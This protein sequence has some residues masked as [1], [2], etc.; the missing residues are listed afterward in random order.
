MAII[1][2][3]KTEDGLITELPVLNKIVMGRSGISD[4]KI[5]DIKMSGKHCSFEVNG[6]GQLLFTDLG[7]TNGSFL[8]N[9]QVNKTMV[10]VND[11]IRIGNTLIKIDEKRLST[12]E[13]LAIGSSI[14][15]K[16]DEKTL[17]DIS[18]LKISPSTDSEADEDSPKKKTIFLN[19]QHKE[20]KK[21][22]SNW[23]SAENV[24][25]QEESSG[26]TR[27][28]KLDSKKKK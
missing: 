22:G 12:S 10:R 17:P 6:K 7:S 2:I 8:N 19:K 24:I 25:E 1:L 21:P 26:N 28:L 9:S 20:K 16:K 27:F 13:R 18:K 15:S 5:V 4:Y 23:A 3:I 11:V 14:L